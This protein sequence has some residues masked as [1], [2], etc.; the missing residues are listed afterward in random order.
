MPTIGYIHIG[1]VFSKEEIE[2]ELFLRQLAGINSC[3]DDKKDVPII[4]YG[5]DKEVVKEIN[6]EPLQGRSLKM[7]SKASEKLADDVVLSVFVKLENDQVFYM[8][9]NLRLLLK[10][11]NDAE[12]NPEIDVSNY[13]SI[14]YL[15][16]E[17]TDTGRIIMNTGLGFD[18]Q[19][20]SIFPM[21]KATK[22]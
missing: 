6:I 11:M 17:L 8:L 22:P 21:V 1:G 14:A 7:I 18:E 4:F 5:A 20:I 10:C 9:M 15:E 2:N 16:N 3:Y 13:G 12:D 19:G